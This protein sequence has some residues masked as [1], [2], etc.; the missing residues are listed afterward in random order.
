VIIWIVIGAYNKY[1]YLEFQKLIIDLYMY[2][3][4]SIL[5]FQVDL[6]YT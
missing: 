2:I 1:T 5:A 4:T 6:L 3:F